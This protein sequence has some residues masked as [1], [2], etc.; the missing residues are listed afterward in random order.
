MESGNQSSKQQEERVQLNMAGVNESRSKL[1]MSNSTV[2]P[3]T[4]MI[5]P[6]HK[7]N[8]CRE[9]LI[10]GGAGVN[11]PDEDGWMPLMFAVKEIHVQ[12]VNELIKAGADVYN[13]DTKGRTP[14]MLAVGK[15]HS[16]IADL[17]I[18]AA[19]DV[20]AKDSYGFTALMQAVHEDH[21]HSELVDRLIK[22][23]ANVNI[24]NKAGQTAIN[25]TAMWG[26]VECFK[27]LLDAG[28]D[29]NIGNSG[30]NTPLLTSIQWQHEIIMKALLEAGANV[31]H[32]N[33]DG[34]TALICAADHPLDPDSEETDCLDML[35]LAGADVTLKTKKA[36][37][38]CTLQ[39]LLATS[40]L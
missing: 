24:Q 21:E 37:M 30:R 17:L 7:H 2:D 6:G 26:S 19:A 10:N 3:V 34:Q 14:L 20:N 36:K 5:P 32:C 35:L 11:I 25:L 13:P 31:N 33:E 8:R 4:A 38:H 12:Y 29:V 28:A 16:E 9:A 23:G 15:E 40:S 18:K 1:E 39:P 27:L 22:S